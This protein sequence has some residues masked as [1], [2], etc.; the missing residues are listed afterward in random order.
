MKW[1]SRRLLLP[2]LNSSNSTT[3]PPPPPLPP[4]KSARSA[5]SSPTLI[6]SW[7]SRPSRLLTSK[8]T[9][10]PWPQLLPPKSNWKNRNTKS[11]L[12]LLI[13]LQWPTMSLLLLQLP[14][15]SW[16]L[17]PTTA[18]VISVIKSSSHFLLVLPP[19]QYKCWKHTFCA[20][21]DSTETQLN[22]NKKL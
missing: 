8:R 10:L 19:T 4:P 20:L 21:F 17:L 3:K 11:S 2:V 15:G 22:L 5:V 6:P 13:T 7:P 1:I 18:T 16:L 14:L 12:Q 9:K